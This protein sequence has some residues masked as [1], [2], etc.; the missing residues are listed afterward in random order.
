M[1]IVVTGG[2]R[3]PSASGTSAPVL[4][5]VNVSVACGVMPIWV[6]I[7]GIKNGGS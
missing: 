3:L 2:D 5:T 6:K 7:D 1:A 4:C